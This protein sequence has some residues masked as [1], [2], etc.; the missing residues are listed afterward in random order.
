VKKAS[1]LP[2]VVDPSHGTGHRELVR[3]LALAA[4]AVG[5]DGLLIDV[6]P[7]PAAALC[8]GDQ[9]LGWQE[10][11][12]LVAALRGVLTSVGRSLPLPGSG[13]SQ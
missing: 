13:G 1:H 5:A 10:W 8:D 11:L 4:A 12:D 3:P 2:V 9:A 6:H 7:Q